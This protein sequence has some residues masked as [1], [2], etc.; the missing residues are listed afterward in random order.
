MFSVPGA[1]VRKSSIEGSEKEVSPVAEVW[2]ARQ[3]LA[4]GVPVPAT[5]RLALIVLYELAQQAS[6]G[7]VG[8]WAEALAALP[9]DGQHQESEEAESE[10]AAGLREVYDK[11]G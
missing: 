9:L 1:L 2:R 7:G 8:S 6:G 10:Q 11:V 4:A 5:C 3:A